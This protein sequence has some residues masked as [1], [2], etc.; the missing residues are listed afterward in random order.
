MYMETKELMMQ[1]Q[2]G[3]LYETKQGKRFRVTLDAG[4][5][6]CSSFGGFWYRDGVAAGKVTINGKERRPHLVREV[7]EQRWIPASREEWGSYPI[8]QRIR[9]GKHHQILVSLDEAKERARLGNEKAIL[10]RAA[11]SVRSGEVQVKDSWGFNVGFTW[12]ISNDKP[13]VL[14][15]ETT[16]GV[17][18]S[19]PL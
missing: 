10:A 9:D 18:I 11:A 19:L 1:L 6:V 8:E 5:F 12:A 17:K 16:S 7:L 3:K 14:D 13:A 2:D 15:I 4:F